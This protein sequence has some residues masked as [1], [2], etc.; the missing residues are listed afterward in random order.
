MLTLS[1][2]HRETVRI[3]DD[4]LVTILTIKPRRVLLGIDAPK[5]LRVCRGEL[6]ARPAPEAIRAPSGSPISEG[7]EMRRTLE[8][9]ENFH[10]CEMRRRFPDHNIR[11]RAVNLMTD[12]VSCTL[13]RGQ[14]RPEDAQ[15]LGR[16]LVD[17][18]ELALL[19]TAF[20]PGAAH[21]TPG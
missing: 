5:D 21:A 13:D 16:M 3:G 17:L 4:V 18:H 12:F 19:N 10:V 7:S 14:V 6:L 8:A 9:E 2:M 20:A 1:R 11:A 15:L